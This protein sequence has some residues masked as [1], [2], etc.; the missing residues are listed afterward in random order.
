VTGTALDRPPVVGPA[1]RAL[2]AG[3]VAA[4]LVPA[5]GALGFRLGAGADVL[6]AAVD[7]A[8]VLIAGCPIAVAGAGPAVR[9]AGHRRAAR[10][11]LGLR[12][13]ELVALGRVDTLLLPRTGVLTG[14]VG[15]LRGS[16]A[17]DGVPAAEVL[18]LAAA[19]ERP[20]AHLLAGAITA[21]AGPDVPGVA[22]F[23]RLPG[24]GV[25]GMVSELSGD[26][27]LAHAVVAGSA[28]FL[29]DHGIAL[30]AELAAARAAAEAAGRVAVAVAWDGT[31][32]GVLEVED[33]VRPDTTDGLA[34]LRRLGVRLVLVSGAG[35]AVAAALAE[36]LGFAAD[37]VVAGRPN[38][39]VRRLRADDR[40]VAGS[41]TDLDVTVGSDGLV[42][43]VDA[44]RLARR[45]RRATAA[46]RAAAAGV[47]GAG[48]VAAAVGLLDVV[49]A[50]SVPAAGLLVVTCARLAVVTLRSWGALGSHRRPRP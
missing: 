7:G 29:L 30:P 4:V 20:S 38:G 28:E 39:A 27:V 12:A 24:R 44:V 3:L 43:V 31:A 15:E 32:R 25:R 18:R 22:D 9:H 11:G 21:A 19:V 42:A 34:A 1:R 45:M 50:L 8:A 10:L 16:T 48:A 5:V 26:R 37:E 41:G 35:P 49:T 23:D 46:A 14:G 40:T 47:A 6:A 13:P 33:P 17:V 36:R 2:P